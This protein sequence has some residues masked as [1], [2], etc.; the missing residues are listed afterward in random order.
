MTAKKTRITATF[1]DCGGVLLTNGW[2]HA[3]RRNVV[4]HFG[5]NFEEFEQR[6]TEPNDRWERGRITLHEYLQETVFYFPRQFSEEEF[7]TQMRAVSRVLYPQMI[8]FL[9]KLRSQ[10]TSTDTP[11]MYLLSNESR[12]LM[13]YRIHEFGLTGLFDA[14][15]VSSYIGLR[16]PEAAFFQCALDISQRAPEQCVFID[17][18]EENVAAAREQ[19]I[20]GIRMETPQQVIAE[21]GRLGIIAA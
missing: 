4:E 1:W 7:V 17:D 9:R 8:A 3:E 15:F 14:Y 5:L 19:G 13:A 18:R 10:S 12:E 21:L 16:K 20:H 6:H 2:D 11:G